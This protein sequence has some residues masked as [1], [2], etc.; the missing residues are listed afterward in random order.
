MTLDIDEA[1]RYLGVRAADEG[2]RARLE[3]L[4]AE[5]QSRIRPRWRWTLTDSAALN[6]PGQTAAAMLADCSRCAVL[7]CTLG[8]E[9]DLWVRREQLRDM[10][11]S[12]LL[13]ALG[14]AWVEAGCDAAEEEIRARFPHLYLTDRFSPGY[15]DLPLTVQPMLLQ[16]AGGDRLGVTLTDSCLMLPQKSV[17][18]LIGLSEKPQRARIRGCACCALNKTCEYRKAGTTCHV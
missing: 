13:D 2:L 14:S 10:A 17:T 16:L 8:A 4:A 18:A 12:A 15:G 1:L 5:V 9:F 11:R 7:V 3:S 6:L